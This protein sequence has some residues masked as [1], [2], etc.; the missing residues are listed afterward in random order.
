MGNTNHRNLPM[1]DHCLCKC[2]TCLE[3]HMV[4]ILITHGHRESDFH[5]RAPPAKMHAPAQ[6]AA[7]DKVSHRAQE[8]LLCRAVTP[9]LGTKD[10]MVLSGCPLHF[11]HG[12]ASGWRR[13]EG[14]VPCAYPF[15]ARIQISFG[16]MGREMLKKREACADLAAKNLSLSFPAFVS[17][18]VFH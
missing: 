13:P 8:Q 3:S 2:I 4:K 1:K 16:V 10:W 15:S 6:E 12:W 9:I 5:A 17:L 7:D 18:N 14:K 11:Q